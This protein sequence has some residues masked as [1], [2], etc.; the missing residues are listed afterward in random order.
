MENIE[1]KK[2]NPVQKIWNVVKKNAVPVL[3][4]ATAVVFVADVK[5][6]RGKTLKATK[7][8]YGTCKTK[9]NGVMAK[10]NVEATPQHV[11]NNPRPQ[12]NQPKKDWVKPTVK[13]S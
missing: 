2:T 6:V 1:E 12:G 9:V 4:G 10:R 11:N 13:Q 3:L 8:A 7:K 5:G